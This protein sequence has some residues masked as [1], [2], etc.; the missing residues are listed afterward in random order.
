M[1][2]LDA[3]VET[4]LVYNM[5]YFKI[6]NLT[7][8]FDIDLT[9]LEKNFLSEQKKFHPDNAT[10]DKEKFQFLSRSTDLN[11]AYNILK[12]DYLRGIYLLKLSDVD[13][14]DDNSRNIL[15]KDFLVYIFALSE[16][17]EEL[18]EFEELEDFHNKITN[19]TK[20]LIIKISHYFR[21]ED[22]NNTSISLMKLKYYNN[23]IKHIEGKIHQ[24]F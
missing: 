15:D 14:S 12:D 23:I 8:S 19:E 21:N 2:N 24:C 9:D 10:N 1:K 4:L 7:K 16:K 18:K 22:V 6:L 13:I 17:I 5:D 11:N 3:A 20:D